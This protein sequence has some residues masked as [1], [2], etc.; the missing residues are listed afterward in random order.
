M[1][2][3]KQNK[4]TMRLN[5]LFLYFKNFNIFSLNEVHKCDTSISKIYLNFM[6]HSSRCE[7]EP[8]RATLTA[9][10]VNDQIVFFFL[11]LCY[12]INTI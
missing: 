7:R 8:K 10:D 9:S 4:K 12:K 5:S 6:N 1:I 11:F 2:R 3:T